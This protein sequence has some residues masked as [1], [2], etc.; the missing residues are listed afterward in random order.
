MC[1]IKKD[2]Y[3]V[4]RNTVDYTCIDKN[5]ICKLM[6][7]TIGNGNSNVSDNDSSSYQKDDTNFDLVQL[8]FVN[9]FLP[10]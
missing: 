2:K 8:Y 4:D 10:F 3:L 9:L 7:Y 5:A 1:D 6:K